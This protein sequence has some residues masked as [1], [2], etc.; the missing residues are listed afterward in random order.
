MD[1]ARRHAI[2]PARARTNGRRSRSNP[3]SHSGIYV[4]LSGKKQGVEP[5]FPLN[6]ARSKSLTEVFGWMWLLP[7]SGRYMAGPGHILCYRRG[8]LTDGTS[9][10]Q[11]AGTFS[12]YFGS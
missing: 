4:C 10:L 1:G 11:L 8:T 3:V 9:R 5:G 7:L 2:P 6:E 12:F